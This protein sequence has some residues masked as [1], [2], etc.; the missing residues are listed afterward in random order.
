MLYVE[1]MSKR[2]TGK[3]EKEEATSGVKDKRA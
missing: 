1:E 2:K 3:K